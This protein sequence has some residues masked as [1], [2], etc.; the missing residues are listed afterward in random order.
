MALT[1]NSEEKLEWE[2]KLIEA[3]FT[4]VMLVSMQDRLRSQGF[5]PWQAGRKGL[6]TRLI[7]RGTE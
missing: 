7:D 3:G 5:I 6:P 2:R 1:P 4:V